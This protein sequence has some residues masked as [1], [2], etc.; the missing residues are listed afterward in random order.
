MKNK[1]DKLTEIYYNTNRDQKEFI[2]QF[3]FH[4]CM[5]DNMSVDDDQ[6]IQDFANRFNI[7][8]VQATLMKYKGWDVMA[9]NLK[10][11]PSEVKEF[12]VIDT[13][14]LLFVGGKI[15]TKRVAQ[16]MRIFNRIGISDSKHKEIYEKGKALS[17]FF[18]Y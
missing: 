10:S 17:E 9:D 6:K 4:I 5:A 14:P 7:I 15:N 2:L 18:N 12:L 16:A 8:N 13:Q 3:V 1:T 11:L